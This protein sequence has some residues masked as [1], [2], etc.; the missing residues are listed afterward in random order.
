MFLFG[1]LHLMKTMT[2]ES[3]CILVCSIDEKTGFCRGCG[4]TRGEIASWI[5]YTSEERRSVM[6]GLADRLDMLG[7]S[8]EPLALARKSKE[9]T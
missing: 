6:A 9:R 3:P 1:K 5:S 8:M 2:I 4:R 7:Q